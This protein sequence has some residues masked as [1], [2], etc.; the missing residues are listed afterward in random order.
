[1][2]LVLSPPKRNLLLLFL[3]IFILE[4]SLTTVY[5]LY[6]GVILTDP[7]V[8][9]YPFLWINSSIFVLLRI[10]PTNIPFPR[11]LPALFLGF[12]YFV[13]LAYLSSILD[14]GHIFHGHTISNHDFG[15][16]V[17]FAPMPPGWAPSIFYSGNLVSIYALF[18][19]LIGYLSLSYLFYRS[20]LSFDRFA[21]SGV[22]G[23]FSCVGCTLWPLVGTYL[24]S[25][26]G[27]SLHLFLS[28][29]QSYGFSTLIFITA[30]S[31]LF[32]NL[33]KRDF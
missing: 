11:K 20:V 27:S 33:P 10:L 24:T 16:R 19:E 28:T 9:L 2:T 5:L 17:A 25:I 4:F 3:F 13:A 12:L 32:W 30:L 8:L 1:M 29:H 14:P 23:V 6:S 7:L 18:F 22:I 26:S 21:L 31:L 15:L